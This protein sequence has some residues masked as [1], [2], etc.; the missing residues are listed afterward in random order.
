MLHRCHSGF[1][2]FCRASYAN[3][4][5]L[6]QNWVQFEILLANIEV[7]DQKHSIFFIT[8]AKQPVAPLQAESYVTGLVVELSRALKYT[9]RAKILAKDR[10]IGL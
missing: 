8:C 2:E 3:L 9:R 10:L 6:L 5:G 7:S 1:Y 4:N